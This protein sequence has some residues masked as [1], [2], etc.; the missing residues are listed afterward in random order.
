MKK[1]YNWSKATIFDLEADGLLREATKVHVLC[2]HMANGKDVSIKG[3]DIER[4]KAFFNYHIEGKIPL[5]A[6]NAVCFDVPL[7]EKLLGIDLSELML[8]DSLALSWY[9]NFNRQRH[10]LGTFHEDYGIE[11]P[12]V[13]DWENLTYEEYEHRCKEDVKINVALW[14]DLKARLIDLYTTA[15]LE[16]DAGSVGGKRMSDDEEIYLDQ[17]RG[18]SVESA[19]D[20]ILTFLM[21]KMDCARLQE[22]TGWKVDTELLEKSVLELTEEAEKAKTELESVMPI[23]PKYADRKAPAKP[24]LKNGNLSASGEAWEKVKELIKNKSVD[25]H[26]NPMVKPSTKEGYVKVL[27]G[28]DAPNA[29]SPEQIKAFLYAKGWVPASFKYERDEEA[30]NK[31]IASKP[32]EGATRQAWNRWKDSRPED[33]AIPQITVAGDEGKE[34]CHSLEE[35]AEEV[36][37]I[38]VYSKYCVLK[39]R[40]GVLKGFMR[41]MYEGKLQARINGFTNTLRVQHAECVNLPGVDKPYGKIIRGVL[42]AGD[43]R[44]SVGSDLSSLEDRTKHHFMLPHDPEYVATMQEDDFDPHILMAL[45]AKMITQDEFDQWKLGNKTANAKAARK[46]GKTTNYASVYNAGAAKIAQAAGVSAEEGK[47]LHDAY[48]KL[49]WAVKAIAGEQ[50]VIKDAK[51]NKWLV[52]PI[53]GFCYALR[54]ESDRFST[55]AQGT[56]SFFFDMWVDAILGQ[57]HQKYG[58]KTLTGSFHDENILV[59]RDTPK[60]R[61]EFAEI[62]SS[63][64]DIVNETYKLRRKLGCDTQYGQRYADIH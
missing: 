60:F 34:L 1:I 20:R 2:C 49:N 21:F 25:E 38:R 16:I 10:G 5:V 9:L 23:V 51:G 41:D 54:K 39:H 15:Q 59:I 55:L 24:F 6:H 17:F 32:S 43:G 45:T 63:S 62:I 31:W 53:N 50:V 8:I 33:R 13:D 19:I 46:N 30:F 29:N 27:N 14:E 26:G 58:K 28:Y 57:M 37:E 56:G 42:I 64:I 61:A 18:Q 11:K 48:W 22:K 7:V 52:N 4:I 36:P 3:S 44:V 40:L 47:I 35:L 12:A